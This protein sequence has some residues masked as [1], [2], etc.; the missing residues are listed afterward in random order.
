MQEVTAEFQNVVP[1][2]QESSSTGVRIEPPSD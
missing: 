1:V 2:D